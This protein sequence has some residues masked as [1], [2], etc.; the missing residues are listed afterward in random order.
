[1]AELLAGGSWCGSDV[2]ENGLVLTLDADI[3]TVSV[4]GRTGHE[5]VP[6]V[7]VVDAPQDGVGS[8]G[9]LFLGKVH[10][11]DHPMQ[12]AAR[13]QR[14][15]DVWRLGPV[16]AGDRPGLEREDAKSAIVVGAAA[17]ASA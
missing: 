4:R 12:Q 2:E 11:G 14:H 5:G 15:V 9:L 1:W 6:C 3:E 16:R 10:A 8:V 7:G 17:T 13:E